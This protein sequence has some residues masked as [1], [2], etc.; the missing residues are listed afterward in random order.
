MRVAK[1]LNKMK[2]KVHTLG[3]HVLVLLLHAAIIKSKTSSSRLLT[4][5]E[6]PSHVLTE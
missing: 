3:I 2:F 1:A 4:T 5:P 6:L